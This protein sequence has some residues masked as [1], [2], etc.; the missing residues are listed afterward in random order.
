MSALLDLTCQRFG[1]L[2]V[3]ER[4]QNRG[5]YVMWRC[6]CDCGTEHHVDGRHLRSGDTRS[7]GCLPGS[8]EQRARAA[9]LATKHGHCRGGKSSPEYGSWRSMIRRC[10]DQGQMNFYSYG[11]RG[12]TVCDRWR[13]GEAGK[14]G[15]ECF[16]AD[17]GPRP[18]GLTL[19]RIEVSGL[20][21][22]ELPMGNGENAS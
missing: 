20:R 8:A 11:G 13:F 17:M 4:G 7:C 16:L 10:Y 1:W 18:P 14:S 5:Q 19:D 2:L 12:I 15:F 21:S 3:V 6:S 22:G 9:A